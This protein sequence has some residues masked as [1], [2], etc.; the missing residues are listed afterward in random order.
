VSSSTTSGAGTASA[1]P[2]PPPALNTLSTPGALGGQGSF[3][4]APGGA[5][6]AGANTASTADGAVT[7]PAAVDADG[8]LGLLGGVIG[9]GVGAVISAG[10][11]YAVVTTTH[12][13]AGIV[14]IAVG[15]IVAQAVVLGA[16]RPSVSLVAPS[17][18]W[19]ILALAVA[20]YLITVQLINEAVAELADGRP[21]LPLL[22]APGDMV[23]LLVAWFQYDPV[24][25]VFWAIALLQAVSIPWRR[26]M[27]PTVRR[28]GSA[29]P[30]PG[31]VA[32]GPT[33]SA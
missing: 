32:S 19:T 30:A 31:P 4:A 16:G 14:A 9:G 12:I 33:P 18:V 23:A 15:F 8:G 22:S 3:A 6:L 2:L 27:R 13:Q 20:Q 5:F 24:T 26:A 1:G 7:V 29:P 25:L 21:A 10:L 28:W 17:V 11:W